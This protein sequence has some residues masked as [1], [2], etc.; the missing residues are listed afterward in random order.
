MSVANELIEKDKTLKRRYGNIICGM[1]VEQKEDFEKGTFKVMVKFPLFT[2]HDTTNS[3][4]N[5]VFAARMRVDADEMNQFVES[6]KKLEEEDEILKLQQ[7]LRQLMSE[8]HHILSLD[9]SYVEINSTQE[10]V[11][12]DTSSFV[13]S[14][15][16]DEEIL[17]IQFEKE[18]GA[19]P[20]KEDPRQTPKKTPQNNQILDV[21]FDEKK[22]ND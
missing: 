1:C 22:K 8:D 11:N 12:I 19:A 2:E 10:L 9:K 16:E 6:F 17:K 20:K 18:T 15:D 3:F 5:A 7:E 13:P 21:E 14:V 4:A